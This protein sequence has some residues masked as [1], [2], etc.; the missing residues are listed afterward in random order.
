LDWIYAPE[1]VHIVV[2]C[3]GGDDQLA[4]TALQSLS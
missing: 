1:V 3:Y 4:E 2:I